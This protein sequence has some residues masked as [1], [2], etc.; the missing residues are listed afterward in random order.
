MKDD[1][2]D[3]LVLSNP[4]SS[5]ASRLCM[6][7]LPLAPGTQA[8]H[9]EGIRTQAQ[10]I[11]RW[12][13]SA[14]GRPGLPRRQLI[15][16]LANSCIPEKI[17]L[18]QGRKIDN[19]YSGPDASLKIVREKKTGI[20]FYEEDEVVFSMGKKQLGLRIGLIHEGEYHW[21]EW[22]RI[23]ELWSGPVC[24]AIRIGG[25]IARHRTTEEELKEINLFTR[26]AALHKLLH[27]HDWLRGEAY[28]L[29]FANGVIHFTCRHVNNHLFDHGRDLE[30]VTPVLAF[31]CVDMPEI[32][33]QI[34]G[35][36]MQFEIGPGVRL[37][38]RETAPMVSSEHPGQL[39]TTDGLLIYK[40]YEGIE[41]VGDG[42]HKRRDD[43]YIVKASE[44][45]FPRGFAKTIHFAAALGEDEPVISRL[46][47]PDWYYAATGNLFVEK[48]LPAHDRTIR[49]EIIESLEKK[50]LA[51]AAKP[52][53]FCDTGILTRSAWEGEIPYSQILHFY[54]SGN[55]D[56]LEIALN[57]IYA[58]ADFGFDH[59]T[60]TWRMHDYPAGCIAP[61]LYRTVGLTFGYLETGDPYLLDCSESAAVRYYQIDRHNW[62]R[63][64]YGR[65]AASL[66]SLAF[67][68]D[69]T[70]KE[71]YL[72]M[73]REAIG[74][75][76]KC[77]RPDGSTGD[78]GGAVDLHG[79]IANEITKTWMAMLASDILID[80]LLRKPGDMEVEKSLVRTAEFM[81]RSQIVKDGVYF[82]AYQYKYGENP[83]DPWGMRDTPD[84]Y[85]KHPFGNSVW[86]YKARFLPFV[87]RL[88]GDTRYLEA[89]QRCVDTYLSTRENWEKM[90][91]GYTSNKFIQNLPFEMAYMWKAQVKTGAVYVEPILTHQNPKI[92]GE[93]STPFGV[94]HISCS[95]KGNK[96]TVKTSCEKKFPVIVRLF[97]TSRQFRITSNSTKIFATG[98]P[99]RHT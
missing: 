34:D 56:F 29:M 58:C 65:D 78:Q 22:L 64:T 20:T 57:D 81:L 4:R 19:R 54:M 32:N 18:V 6:I 39:Q 83:G 15:F 95:R 50:V 66:R 13:S 12:P 48:I 63:R 62:P 75:A 73:A 43:G 80:Y 40:P 45:R 72:A 11:A 76:I 89:W 38:L 51:R 79:G 26:P 5:E 49:D 1:L 47:A 25:F 88:T 96:V 90:E 41:I 53:G 24:K 98:R 7:S 37:D 46:T 42:V 8:G 91:V 33:T 97:G 16:G 67:L 93:I 94:L 21:W 69:Y 87:A 2:L 30:D 59:A 52:S 92:S 71:D 9:L 3:G 74:R 31:T 86:G 77:Q 23:E 55:P 28:I 85:A 27:V 61:P 14:A 84:N 82:W 60:E 70:G 99:V 68:W 10:T 44:K 35:T 36:K 17:R